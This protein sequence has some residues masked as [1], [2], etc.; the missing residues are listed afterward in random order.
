MSFVGMFTD[1]FH[2][3]FKKPFT[4]LYP[5]E[6]HPNPELLR[7]KLEWDATKCTAC[8]LCVRD[9]PSHAIEVIVVDRATK[10]YVMHYEIDRCTFCA[11]CVANCR[12]DALTLSNSKW[13]L[14]SSQRKTFDLYYGNDADIQTVLAKRSSTDSQAGQPK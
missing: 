6:R 10:R 3:L 8:Q 2:S 12:F 14:A 11:Q 7:A 1:V 9:C 5:F 13:E 4:Q